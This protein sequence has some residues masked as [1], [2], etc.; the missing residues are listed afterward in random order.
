MNPRIAIDRLQ[1]KDKTLMGD[2]IDVY[3]ISGNQ[4]FNDCVTEFDFRYMLLHVKHENG[5]IRSVSLTLWANDPAAKNGSFNLS[6]CR[7][8]ASNEFAPINPVIDAMFAAPPFTGSV[9]IDPLSFNALF[10]K[11]GIGKY[12]DSH[13]MDT[14]A[15]TNYKVAYIFVNKVINTAGDIE[16][17]QRACESK[18]QAA[19]G[20]A[21]GSW[22]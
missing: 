3:R 11:S 16:Q 14:D 7:D 5:S 15:K 18:R 12:L 17:R 10:M 20:E 13:Y 1:Y 21:W 2:S 4:N 22:E 6:E 8:T 9:S 19:Y